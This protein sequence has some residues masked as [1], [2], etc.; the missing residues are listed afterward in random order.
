MRPQQKGCYRKD[1]QSSAHN[2]TFPHKCV[3]TVQ[4]AMEQQ[5]DNKQKK[6]DSKDQDNSAAFL[7]SFE[8]IKNGLINTLRNLIRTNP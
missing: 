8:K 1:L 5:K 3:H 6:D 2:R 4:M 7:A